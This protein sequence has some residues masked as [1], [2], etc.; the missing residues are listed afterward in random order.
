[1]QRIAILSDVHA[2]LPALK[3]VLA[4]VARDG[5]IGGIVWLGDMVGY[6]AQPR[7]CVRLARSSGGPC[8]I[9][10]HDQY[11]LQMA[12][13]DRC[14]WEH[15]E[16]DNPVWAGVLHA[17]RELE[18]QDVAWLRGLPWF[19]QIEGAV[20]AHAALHE[21]GR[22]PYLLDEGKAAPTWDLMRE[23]GQTVGFFGHTHRQRWF[24]DPAAKGSPEEQGLG[25]LWVPE[26]AVCSV[27]V[28]SVG[29]PRDGDGRASWVV[30]DPVARLVE[31][32]RTEYPVLEAARA[33]LAAGLPLHS[34]LRLLDP[35][36]ARQLLAES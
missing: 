10:N 21:P 22:W 24:A 16:S 36:Q 4:E 12:Q 15:E 14:R 27:V 34:A 6:G 5:R 23:Q 32:R 2:N 7:E 31:F 1:M 11:A 25:R 29:Q 28:G 30:W 17:A 20:A 3:S 18:P 8:V 26:D 33:I 35:R 9:G 19:V 13:V